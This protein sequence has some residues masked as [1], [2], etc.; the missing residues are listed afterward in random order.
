M[1]TLDNFP[2]FGSELSPD[3]MTYEQALSELERIV[4][5]LETEEMPLETSLSYY[6]R[7]QAVSRRC[8]ALLDQAELRVRLLAGENLVDFEG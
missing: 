4:A 7:G 6:E 8:V 3:Q 5:A 1:T 2:S